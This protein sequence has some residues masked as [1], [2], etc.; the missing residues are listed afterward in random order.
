MAVV[1]FHVL[2]I[3]PRLASQVATLPPGTTE[4]D[5]VAGTVRRVQRL[6][7][8]LNTVCCL[9]I[10][11]CLGVL[12]TSDGWFAL[13]LTLCLG[14]ALLCRASSSRLTAVVAALLLSGLAG[15]GALVLRVPDR[16]SGLDLPGWSGPLA[17]VIVGVVVL[18]AGLVMAFRSSLQQV[19]FGE[20]WRWPGSFGAFLGA[21]SVPLAAGVFGV[22]QAL[23]DAGRG[24]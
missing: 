10:L 19:D 12:S 13:G 8:L 6:L 7:V 2:A 9:A 16:L 11:G 1:V 15:L 14:V 5:D 17:L 21:V 23:L 3:L 24:L 4:M 22:L 18:W 20:R